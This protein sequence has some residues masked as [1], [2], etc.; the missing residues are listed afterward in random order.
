MDLG[1]LQQLQ[2]D[3]GDPGRHRLERAKESLKA[4]ID[5][6]RW[7]SEGLRPSILDPGGTVLTASMPLGARSGH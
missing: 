3:L 7:V 1:A 5:L 6:K 2:P 4:A